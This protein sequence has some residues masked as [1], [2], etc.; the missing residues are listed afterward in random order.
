LFPQREDDERLTNV[1][2]CDETKTVSCS[3][4]T[5]QLTDLTTRL[6]LLINSLQRFDDN[7]VY[8]VHII[9]FVNLYT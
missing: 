9:Q 5:G 6:N 7:W 3:Q 1:M 8:R 4:Q 2:L